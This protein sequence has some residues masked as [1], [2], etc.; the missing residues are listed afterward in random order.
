MV[1]ATKV[2]NNFLTD[3]FFADFLKLSREIWLILRN[4]SYLCPINQIIHQTIK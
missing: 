1:D 3:E 4:S 2:R